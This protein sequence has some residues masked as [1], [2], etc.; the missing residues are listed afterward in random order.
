[1]AGERATSELPPEPPAHWP[2]RVQAPPEPAPQ[3]PSRRGGASVIIAGAVVFALLVTYG[4]GQALVHA[5][6]PR[7]RGGPPSLPETT[8]TAPVEGLVPLEQAVPALISFVEEQRGARFDPV[9]DVTPQEDVEYEATASSAIDRDIAFARHEVTYE[10]LG[11][12][13]GRSD[14]RA[15]LKLL[16]SRATV[17][18]YDEASGDVI[19]RGQTTTPYIRA[20]I[21]AALTRAL[22]QQLPPADSPPVEQYDASFAADA[23]AAGSAATVEAAYVSQLD[24]ADQASYGQDLRQAQGM[25]GVSGAGEGAQFIDALPTLVGRQFAFH[26]LNAGAGSRAVD[27]AFK[28][29]PTTSEQVFDTTAYDAK[30]R[31]LAVDR[32]PEPQGRLIDEGRFGMADVVI[33]LA[34][35]I[36]LA[37]EA[38]SH[39]WGGGRFQTWVN[40]GE[41]LCVRARVAGDTDATTARLLTRFQSWASRVGPGASA[42]SVPDK[43]LGRAAVEIERCSS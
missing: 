29:P 24:Q 13:A 22:D 12:D 34:P 6:D 5:D 19:V 20:N 7:R 21:V 28:A 23:L 38:G 4:L 35:N 10:A 17:A 41:E 25:R 42:V 39:E 18:L 14:L 33:A 43:A 30:Q 31:P 36:D 37:T 32:Y 40:A 3:G 2:A 11:V 1:M 8:T 15:G 27:R 26:L 16:A 9:P